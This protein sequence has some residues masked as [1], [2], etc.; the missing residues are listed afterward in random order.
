MRGAKNS[1]NQSNVSNGI[2]KSEIRGDGDALRDD[3][4]S[5]FYLRHANSQFK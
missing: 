2:V 3:K 1:S 4:S 5:R